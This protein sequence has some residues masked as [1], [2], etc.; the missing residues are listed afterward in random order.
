M[1]YLLEASTN[2]NR[3]ESLNRDFV[4]GLP[5]NIISSAWALN[6]YF[7]ENIYNPVRSFE[8][9][10]IAT[11]S[12]REKKMTFDRRTGALRTRFDGDSEWEQREI[13]CCFEVRAELSYNSPKLDSA[14]SS[15]FDTVCISRR[16][17]QERAGSSSS[18]V[19]K[20]VEAVMQTSKPYFRQF[21]YRGSGLVRVINFD[22]CALVLD[23]TVQ[24]VLMDPPYSVRRLRKA[25][26]SAHDNLSVKDMRT[27][28]ELDAEL[29]RPNGH[30]II[31][32]TAQQFAVWHTLFRVPK[33][34]HDDGSS[35]SS[36]T[37]SRDLFMVI[38][39]PLTF[40]DEPFRK[41]N[42]SARKSCVLATSVE[43]VMHVKKNK[44]SPVADK[45][46][47]NY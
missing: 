1:P 40:V 38:A 14:P 31:F 8:V 34:T 5:S 43:F 13:A 15:K 47:V 33:S 32:C 37:P 10:S 36:A 7:L 42:N 3:K 2:T 39:A 9:Y 41:H 23:A 21:N 28:L 26:N 45:K 30:E 46:M 6:N 35:S 44:L 25:K 17:T 11:K 16:S 24:L 29:L 4:Q 20:R 12:K 22:V 19:E 18:S 27:T